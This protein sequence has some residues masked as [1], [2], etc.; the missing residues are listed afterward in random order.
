VTT[1]AYDAAGNVTKMYGP[2][3]NVN[4]FHDAL[5][6][7]SGVGFGNETVPAR[8]TYDAVGN[9]ASV[10]YGN[11]VTHNYTYDAKNRLK[12]LGVTNAG[13]T[14][15]AIAGYAYTVDAAGHRTSVTELSGRTVNYGYDSIYRLTSETIAS[16]PNA[17]NGAVSYVYDPVGNRTQKVSTLAGFPGGLSNYN[18]NDE[19]T[20]DTYDAAGNTTQSQGLGYVYDFENHLVQA[21]AGISFVYDGDG[22]RVQKTVAGVVTRYQVATLNPTGY[23]QVIGEELPNGYPVVTYVYGLEQ[24]SRTDQ[25]ASVTSYYVHDGHGSVRALTDVNGNVT[26]TYDYDAFGNLIHST[27]TSANN[28]LFAGEQFDLDLGLY[29][30]RAR[31][32]STSTGRFWSMDDDAYGDDEVPLSLHEYLYANADPIDGHDS[33]GHDD[34][35]GIGID[36]TLNAISVLPNFALVLNMG[37]RQASTVSVL[38]VKFIAAE[39]GKKVRNGR[40]VL[41]NDSALN[42]TIGYGH[43]VHYHRCDGTEPADFVQGISLQRALDFLSTDSLDAVT[44][45]QRNTT[46]PLKQQEFDAVTSFIF[47]EGEGNYQISDLR[48]TLNQGQYSL[49]PPLFLH[50][51]RAGTDPN[52]LLGRR[53]DESNLFQSGLYRARGKLIN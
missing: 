8:Y 9:L 43:L 3:G 33:S 39:E 50:F 41:Y 27:G 36:M 32:L 35:S 44:K 25:L 6:R 42:C 4:Y 53:Q 47:N 22:N 48:K 1:F 20:T 30:N 45:L 12:T 28:Y 5:N 11:G 31:Y 16:D 40:A 52:V 34:V 51:T 14:P 19:L 26:D 24:I 38:G 46:V 10:A 23:A 17:V 7:L 18:A 49:V 21:G 29:Y 37:L 15:V 13:A 2:G